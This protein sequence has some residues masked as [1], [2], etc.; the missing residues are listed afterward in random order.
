MAR[1]TAAQTQERRRRVDAL[2]CRGLSAW[3]IAQ[4]LKAHLTT[5]RAD[6]A[7]LAAEREHGISVAG[8]RARLLEAARE[9]ERAAWTLH[10]ELP[11]DDA[12][13]RIGA[14]GKVLAAQAQSRG[15]LGDIAES[16]IERRLA[17]LK[18]AA[19]ATTPHERARTRWGL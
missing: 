14:L 3:A 19:E 18:A 8:E 1:T 11:A 16:D 15:M 4:E 6:L 13:G 17:A 12:N 9:V 5:I 10:G 2:Q 7:A